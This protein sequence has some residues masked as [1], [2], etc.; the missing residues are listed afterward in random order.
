VTGGLGAVGTHLVAELERRGHD[1]FVIDIR[2]HHN[3][4][5]Y[6]RCDVSE[7]RQVE[8]LWTGGG[9]PFGY[10]PRGRRFDVVYHLAA[11]FGRWNGEDYYE[12]LWSANVVG[13]KNILRMQ[14]REGFKAVYFS[15]SE[16]YGDYEGT[17][18]EDVMDRVEIKQLNDYAM[19]K[20]VN[21]QQVL[22]SARQFGTKSVRVRLF[23]TYGPGEYYSPYRSVICLFC[24]RALHGIPYVVYRGHKRTSTYV[25]DTSRTLANIAD[26]FSPG[27]VYNI[28]GTDYHDIETCSRIILKTLRRSDKLL[29]SYRDAEIMTTR[30][31]LVDCSKAVR[32]LGHRTTVTL[33]EGIRRT[34]AWMQRTYRPVEGHDRTAK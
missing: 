10:T 25:T 33:E 26:A 17:M 22:N 4:P 23:N 19:T 28:G 11:E 29:V 20:W 2:H 16:V 6:A 15:S 27:V 9:W 30:Q 18:S 31:K 12:N 13:T 5:N 1:V 3:A 32:E 24:Y 8:R 7:Y 21:E 34:L 14:E